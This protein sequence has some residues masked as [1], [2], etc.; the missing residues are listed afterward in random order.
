MEAGQT[1]VLAEVGVM[2]NKFASSCIMLSLG[3]RT[4]SIALLQ[5]LTALPDNNLIPTIWADPP[6]SYGS[7]RF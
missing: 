5:L 1:R 4:A 2:P 6:K 7:T 3:L